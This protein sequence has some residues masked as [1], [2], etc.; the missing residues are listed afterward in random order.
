MSRV[1]RKR[2]ATWGARSCSRSYSDGDDDEGVALRSGG[3]S[4]GDDGGGTPTGL[5]QGMTHC[6]RHCAPSPSGGHEG[7]DGAEQHRR[8]TRPHHT[9]SH[10]GGQG[11]GNVAR[12]YCAERRRPGVATT[13]VGVSQAGRCLVPVP[14]RH[15]TRGTI[16]RRER[17]TVSPT[18]SPPSSDPES[19]A[20]T[21]RDQARESGLV[22]TRRR[23]VALN[24]D[25]EDR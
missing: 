12:P 25:D 8:H 13:L 15:D 9:A 1:P 23:R 22:W 18:I 19:R 14:F 3:L 6:Q 11:G 16:A 20:A 5:A 7:V 21:L 10:A 24:D 17:A 2:G 4:D